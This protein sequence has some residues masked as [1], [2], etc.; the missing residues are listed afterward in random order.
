MSKLNV[1]EYHLE[2]SLGFV[3]QYCKIADTAH[4]YHSMRR[5]INAAYSK[6]GCGAYHFSI[7]NAAHN[8]Y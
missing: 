3:R 8:E 6:K 1:G 5:I 2:Q 4:S 7:S